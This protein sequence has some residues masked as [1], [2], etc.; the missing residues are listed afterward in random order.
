MSVPTVKFDDSLVTEAV[1]NNL[2]AAVDSLV[3]IEQSYFERIYD[4]ALK[5]VSAGRDLGSLYNELVAMQIVGLTKKR[6]A[7][8][9]LY[10]NNVATSKIARERQLQ[11]GI[12]E[13]KWMYSGAPCVVKTKN[14]SKEIDAAHKTAN[15]LKYKIQDGL[16][17][18]GKWTWPGLE[19]GCKCIGMQIIPGLECT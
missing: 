12:T 3:G 1:R 16:Y 8:I 7:E 2:K 19:E 9:S 17:L 18:C 14:A 5:S 13:A 6:A 15:G 11:L 10:L 4:V